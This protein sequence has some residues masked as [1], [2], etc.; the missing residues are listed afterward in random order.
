[1][2]TV[3]IRELKNRLSSYLRE[4]R[5][6]RTVAIT[7]R[8]RV[9]AEL[10]PPRTNGRQDA[11][12]ELVRRGSITLRKNDTRAGRPLNVYAECSCPTSRSSNVI[13]RSSGPP[14]NGPLPKPR[15]R[16]FTRCSPRLRVGGASC[17]F[18][19]RRGTQ[20]SPSRRRRR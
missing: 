17:G 15:P 10:T 9:V 14:S 13:G 18:A 7:D 12:A 1:M 6:G 2:K 11:F 16:T 5:A 4:V 3:G 19:R 8:G 20:G